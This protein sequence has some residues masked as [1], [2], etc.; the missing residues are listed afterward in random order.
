[1]LLQKCLDPNLQLDNL[2]CMGEFDAIC[3][4]LVTQLR[5]CIN[6]RIK[7]LVTRRFHN[8][9]ILDS[10]I[11]KLIHTWKKFRLGPS[12]ESN[13][14]RSLFFSV[15][16]MVFDFLYFVFFQV[17][18]IIAG[19]ITYKFLHK[20]NKEVGNCFEVQLDSR[21]I[22]LYSCHSQGKSSMSLV[23]KY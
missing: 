18:Y 19:K 12:L 14:T 9:K 13:L 5:F 21:T 16:I 7:M 22:R 20:E 23:S 6:V 11:G 17:Q 2:T 1:M 15:D 10:Q 8:F 3:F 4:G